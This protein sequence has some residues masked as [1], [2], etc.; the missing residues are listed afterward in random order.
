MGA[1][2]LAVLAALIPT[3]GR[4]SRHN[5]LPDML[6]VKSHTQEYLLTSGNLPEEIATFSVVI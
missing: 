4:C 3:L 2:F 6:S 5:S 1:F